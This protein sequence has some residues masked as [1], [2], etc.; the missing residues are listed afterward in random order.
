MSSS[1]MKIREEVKIMDVLEEPIEI[2]QS[3]T[4]V[5]MLL[6]FLFYLVLSVYG[7]ISVNHIIV[8]PNKNQLYH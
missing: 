3:I 5:H 4:R 2:T 8:T 6:K 1:A 7:K